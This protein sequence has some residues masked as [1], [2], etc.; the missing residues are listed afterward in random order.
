V[1]FDIEAAKASPG[2]WPRQ[3]GGATETL[4]LLSVSG[5]DFLRAVE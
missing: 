3:H 1:G 2:A 4:K 5:K